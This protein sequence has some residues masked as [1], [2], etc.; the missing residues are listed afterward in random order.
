MPNRTTPEFWTDD[1]TLNSLTRDAELF[2]RKVQALLV[3]EHRFS[4]VPTPQR[5]ENL[6]AKL[7][8]L[9]RGVTTKDVARWLDENYRAGTILVRDSER[10]WYGEIP[11]SLRYKAEDFAKGATR[12]GPREMKPI[13]QGQL[14]LGPVGLVSHAAKTPMPSRSYEYDNGNDNESARVRAEVTRSL[15]RVK[16]SGRFAASEDDVDDEVWIDLCRVLPARE[17]VSNGAAWRKRI[18]TS[19]RAIAEGVSEFLALG[20]EQKAGVSNPAAWLVAKYQQLG[21]QTVAA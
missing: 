17:L 14:P 15:S 13:A 10:G 19:R 5:P 3:D 9:R 16:D 20:P 18:A 11:E 6:R 21:G 8:Y 12:V 4:I 2:F 7:Y 1:V